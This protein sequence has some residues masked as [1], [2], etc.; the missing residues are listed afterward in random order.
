MAVILTEQLGWGLDFDKNG[1]YLV[2]RN[3]ALYSLS[4][5]Y[6]MPNLGKCMVF[7]VNGL[8]ENAVS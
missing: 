3:T 8:K 2:F 6:V 7:L 4:Q 5:M 1:F